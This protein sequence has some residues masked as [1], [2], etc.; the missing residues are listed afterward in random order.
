[1]RILSTKRG[2]TLIESLISLILLSIVLTG[3]MQ[4]YFNSQKLVS[5]ASH[6]RLAL[7]I[8]NARLEEMRKNGYGALPNPAPGPGVVTT[9]TITVGGLTASRVETVVD[10]DANGDSVTDYKSVDVEVS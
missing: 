8:A 6:K 2:F 7:H 3:G 5:L 1:M 10:V 4:F 9:T